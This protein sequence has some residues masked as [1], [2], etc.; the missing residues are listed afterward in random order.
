MM[1]GYDFGLFGLEAEEYQ[2]GVVDLEM[3]WTW[4]KRILINGYMY[5]YKN[6]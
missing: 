1:Y 2:V 6:S 3:R 4:Y 5:K